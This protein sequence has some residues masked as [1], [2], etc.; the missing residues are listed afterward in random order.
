MIIGGLKTMAEFLK[1]LEENGHTDKAQLLKINAKSRSQY[2]R[3]I[4]IIPGVHELWIKYLEE[5]R[6]R[7]E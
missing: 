4:S 3:L 7:K 6:D 5:T 1:W 2:N